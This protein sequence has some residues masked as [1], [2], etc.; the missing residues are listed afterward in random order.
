[1]DKTS[2]WK[3]NL[4]NTICSKSRIRKLAGIFGVS[5]LC[6]SISEVFSTDA[7]QQEYNITENQDPTL[8]N[9]SISNAH[10]LT[11]TQLDNYM[12]EKPNMI[13]DSIR[14][15]IPSAMKFIKRKLN[16]NKNNYTTEDK[17]LI[18][19]LVNEIQKLLRQESSTKTEYTNIL[20]KIQSPKMMF[21][22]IYKSMKDGLGRDHQHEQYAIAADE[23]IRDYMSNLYQK[24]Y[25][26]LPVTD[27]KILSHILVM[28]WCSIRDTQFSNPYNLAI[29]THKGIVFAFIETMDLFLEIN[30]GTNHIDDMLQMCLDS[31]DCLKRDSNQNITVYILNM[32]KNASKNKKL[33]L[34]DTQLLLFYT[35][36]IISYY[37]FIARQTDKLNRIIPT[38]AATLITKIKIN[39]NWNK[40]S[41]EDFIDLIRILGFSKMQY[42]FKLHQHKGALNKL[43][44]RL[45]NSYDDRYTHELIRIFCAVLD[46][47]IDDERVNE[48]NFDT[49]FDKIGEAI[50]N[51]SND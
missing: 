20:N 7:S 49:Y 29:L 4:H 44:K 46:I 42:G 18:Q 19:N 11:Q 6:M 45:R 48:A 33:N 26:E 37:Y 34:V 2:N 25:T 36:D 27:F 1:M 28:I 39:D 16:N 35:K 10:P 51:M 24:Q 17:Q 38:I 8:E 13:Q 14:A 9:I 15:P 5:L 23:W 30:K 41:T 40:L 43:Y 50:E 21:T 22:V 31:W 32:L 12:T 47:Q 3:Y